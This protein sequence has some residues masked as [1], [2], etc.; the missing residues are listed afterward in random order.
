MKAEGYQLSKSSRFTYSLDV[1]YYPLINRAA[2]RDLF[3]VLGKKD[4]FMLEERKQQ[5]KDYIADLMQLTEKEH[6]YLDRF[7][8]KEYVPELLF[9]NEVIVERIKG[10]PMAI[11]KCQQ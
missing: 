5:A 6:E 3:P 11:R 4:N 2:A 7:I 9:D 1:F 10:H 8:A